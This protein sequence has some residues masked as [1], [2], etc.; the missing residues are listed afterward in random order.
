V[1]LLGAFERM[2][3]G[4]GFPRNGKNGARYN[5]KACWVTAFQNPVQIVTRCGL[6]KATDD[7]VARARK[8]RFHREAR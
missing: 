5:R 8:G 7:T 1:V 3:F 2:W 6:T 4:A